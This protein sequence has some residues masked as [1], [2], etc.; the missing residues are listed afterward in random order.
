MLKRSWGGL[1]HALTNYVLASRFPGNM[2][3]SGL[4]RLGAA[5][6]K[7]VNVLVVGEGEAHDFTH[8]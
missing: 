1:D 2:S 8:G 3:C 7:S 5:E 4:F 6:G